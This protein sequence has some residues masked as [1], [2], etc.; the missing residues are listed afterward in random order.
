[1]SLLTESK[2]TLRLALPLMIGQLS[3]MLLG[4]ADTL[5][6]GQL[7]VTELATLTFVNSLFY[8]PFVFSIGLLTCI[9]VHTSHSRGAGDPTA[10]RRSCRNGVYLALAIS[11]MFLLFSQILLPYLNRF[12]QPPSVVAISHSY[13]TI[14][15]MSLVP[16]LMSMALKNHADALDRPWP[17]FWI[18][19]GGVLFNILLN[20]LL[21][22][23]KWGCPE[24][25]MNGAAWATL[26]SRVLIMVALFL[27]LKTSVSLRDWVP[28]SWFR[29]PQKSDLIAHA[30][31]GLPASFQ[32][33][34]EVGAFSAAGFM[35]GHFGEVPMAAHQIAITCASSAFMIPLGLAMALTVRTGAVAGAKET[36]RLRAVV[37]SGWLLSAAFGLMNATLFFFGGRFAAEQFTDAPDVISLTILLLGIVSVFQIFDSVQVASASMLRGLHDTRVPALMG[38][39]AYWAVGLPVA[40][41]LSEILDW[42]ARGVWWG[43]AAGLFVACVTLGTR[44]RQQMIRMVRT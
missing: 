9:S 32:M 28:F 19:L 30:K 26:I 20:W 35:I 8:L 3:Q 10:A 39:L 34:C 4:V 5:M 17:P 29:K 2:I 15:M 42:E 38:F 24:L 33:L 18:F 43:L 41:W 40:W 25:G 23:G 36:M 7:G 37:H 27:W 22:Y 21:I 11:L 44:L 14:L 16:A 12:G 1:M 6:V 13:F 31:I